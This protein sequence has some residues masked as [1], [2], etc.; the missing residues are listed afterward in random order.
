MASRPRTWSASPYN[1]GAWILGPL[2]GDRGAG[3]AA[4]LRARHCA[5]HTQYQG[6]S[7][8]LLG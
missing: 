1:Y 4:D 8:D 3:T 2:A 6:R 5:F 7:E